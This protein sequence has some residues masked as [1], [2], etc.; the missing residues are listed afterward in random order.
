MVVLGIDA[1]KRTHTVVAVDEVGRQ[2]G[3]MVTKTTSTAAHLELVVWA[4]RFGRER[5]W[6]VEDCRHL[7][8]RLER[9]LLAAGEQIVRVP[10]KLMA[11]A[12][13][14]A[15][16]YGK[17]DPIDALA[18]ARAALREPGLPTA[19]LDGRERELRLLTDHREDL[20]AERTR[21]INRLR[22]HLHELDPGWDPAPRS[23]SRRKHLD[24]AAAR[25]AAMEGMVARIAADLTARIIALTTD[26][27]ALEKQITARVRQ[28]APT[29]LA[30]AG[31]A[32]LTAAKIVAETAGVGRFR[33]KDA[34]ARHNGTAPLP[35]WSGHPARHRLSRTGN[36][37]LNCAI[38]RIAVT[39]KRCHPPAQA[40]LKNR[41]TV[42]DTPAEALRALKR[43]LSD[44]IYRT[45][46][47]DSADTTAATPGQAA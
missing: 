44:I 40:Y 25:L 18:V 34:Y 46:L 22:W 17:S 27:N 30:M 3:V 9:D 1:H 28:L 20:V 14:S 15:R 11:H 23:L 13:D 36:R 35:A 7:S 32:E 37:Q 19:R 2:L 42:G 6:A 43:R 38:H 24:A 41:T 33:S 10:P 12:R 31:T 8:R 21:A 29:L 45:L 39:Q 16:T 4:D 26:I 47:A 5:R